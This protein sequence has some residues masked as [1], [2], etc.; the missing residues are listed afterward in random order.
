MLKKFLALSMILGS[1][2]FTASAAE[3]TTTNNVAGSVEVNAAPQWRQNRNRN[4][5]WNDNRRVRVVNRTR[6]V[7]IGG[8]YY[9][10]VWQYRYMPNGRV[11]TRLIS[12]T[13]VYR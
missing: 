9:R 12:R 10:E 4:R 2:V 5:R 1:M 11:T 7:R 3:A 8:R 13:R 6:I